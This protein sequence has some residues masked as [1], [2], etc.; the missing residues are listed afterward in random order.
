MSG[1]RAAALHIPGLTKSMYYINSSNRADTPEL[2]DSRVDENGC[3]NFSWKTYGTCGLYEIRARGSVNLVNFARDGRPMFGGLSVTCSC[4][5]GE[6]QQALN[7][8]QTGPLSVCKHAGAAL[9][10]VVDPQASARNAALRDKRKVELQKTALTE[11]NR[12]TKM[13]EFVQENGAPLV[14]LVVHDKEP[15]DSGSDW[16]D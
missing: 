9:A 11:A 6:E 8:R 1:K 3:V 12:S 16:T 2:V 15:Q 13:G 5:H 7:R 4:P 10:S 14:Y